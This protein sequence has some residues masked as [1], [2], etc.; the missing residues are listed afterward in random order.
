M[1]YRVEVN[2][3]KANFIDKLIVKP[4]FIKGSQ[5]PTLFIF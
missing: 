1:V 5:L 3:Y 4:I 2:S